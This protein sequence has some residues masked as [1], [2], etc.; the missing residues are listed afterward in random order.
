MPFKETSK[1]TKSL[2]LLFREMFRILLFRKMFCVTFR[3]TDAKQAK[4][5]AKQPLVSLVLLFRETAI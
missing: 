5:F 4:N 1:P 3:E 2:L